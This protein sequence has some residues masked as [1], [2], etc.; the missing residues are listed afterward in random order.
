MLQT[1]DWLS[2]V[3]NM[4][5]RTAIKNASTS[6]T[7]DACHGLRKRPLSAE[8][9]HFHDILQIIDHNRVKVTII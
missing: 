5:A 2:A 7:R 1:P 4:E 9:H 3:Q 8:A 6:Q